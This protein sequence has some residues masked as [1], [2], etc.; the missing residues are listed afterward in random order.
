MSDALRVNGNQLDWGSG[1]FKIDGALYSGVTAIEYSDGLE[2]GLAYGMGRHHGPR[3]RTAGKYTPEPLVVTCWESTAKS[4]RDDLALKA[5]DGR[6]FGRV[7]VPITVQYIEA[8]DAIVTVD[9]QECRL[10]KIETSHEEGPEG[11]Q[12]K[13][14]FSVMRYVYDG[15]TLYDSS[16][17]GGA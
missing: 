7:V 17:E 9:A 12:K 5:P 15:L 13:L 4:I 14:T 1:K 3:G 6:S 11:L 2:V 8:D 16:A 10:V